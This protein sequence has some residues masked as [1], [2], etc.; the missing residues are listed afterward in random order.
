MNE[1]PI[2]VA[3][4]GGIASATAAL[5]AFIGNLLSNRGQHQSPLKALWGKPPPTADLGLRPSQY[6]GRREY[7]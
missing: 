2:L 3:I 7:N 6:D 5:I 4:I 1:I